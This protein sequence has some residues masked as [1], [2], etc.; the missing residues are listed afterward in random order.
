MAHRVN[1]FNS[2]V[3]DQINGRVPVAE[4]TAPTEPTVPTKSSI[5]YM[6]EVIDKHLD[7]E[8]KLQGRA[9]SAISLCP[10]QKVTMV[11]D[12]YAVVE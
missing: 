12:L 4:P 6:V 2:I 8:R 11:S 7:F 5:D 9:L 1:G 3:I 10:A